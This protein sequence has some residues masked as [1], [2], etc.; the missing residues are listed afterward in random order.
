VHI[1]AGCKPGGTVLDLFC[2]TGTTGIA[3]LALGRRFAG[4]ELSPAFAAL[5][6]ERLRHAGQP[7]PSGSE[8][9]TR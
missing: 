4:I 5:A 3:A 9:G 7:E 6:A 2:G 1:K 8:D